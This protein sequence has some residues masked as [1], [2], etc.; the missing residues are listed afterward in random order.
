MAR[1]VT[2]DGLTDNQAAAQGEVHDL[3]QRH[4][5]LLGPEF[6]GDPDEGVPLAAPILT[7]WVLVARWVDMVTD[8]SFTTRI[9][10]RNLPAPMRTG[11][12]HQ[13][14]FQFDD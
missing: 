5:A 3:I 9:G 6:D 11:L 4:A 13:A 10:S 7:E 14:L 8:E 2:G 1:A 12:L